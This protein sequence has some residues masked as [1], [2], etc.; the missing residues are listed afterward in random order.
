M[1]LVDRISHLMPAPDGGDDLIEVGGPDEGLGLGVVLIEE[2]IDRNLQI[3]DRTEHAALQSPFGERG[4]E[5]LDGVE[6]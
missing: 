1:R 4:E 3:E 6:P 5:P 2:A